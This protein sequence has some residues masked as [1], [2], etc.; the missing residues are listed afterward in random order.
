MCMPTSTDTPSTLPL[1]D[2]LR[3]LEATIEFLAKRIN[4]LEH[5]R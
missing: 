1:E 2:R 5:I 3:E 4:E